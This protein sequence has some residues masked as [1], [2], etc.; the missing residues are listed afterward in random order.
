MTKAER[1]ELLRLHKLRY[2]EHLA[3]S[4]TD[5]QL[6][7]LRNKRMKKV[8]RP[9]KKNRGRPKSTLMET[10]FEFQREAGI[11]Y[12]ENITIIARNFKI[13]R[14]KIRNRFPKKPTEK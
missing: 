3:K 13:S 6:R 9:A 5:E 1:E 8:T 10:M 7:Q 11:P 4:L 12:E 2:I 14:D